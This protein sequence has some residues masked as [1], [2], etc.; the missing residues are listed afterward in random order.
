MGPKSEGPSN[1]ATGLSQTDAIANLLTGSVE[2]VAN[3]TKKPAV[4]KGV[5]DTVKADDEEVLQDEQITEEDSDEEETPSDESTDEEVTDESD[6][7]WE[8]ML[9]LEDGQ[10]DF[11]DKGNLRGINVKV[12][13]ESS[14]VKLAELVAGYQ[15]NKSNTQKSQALSDERRNFESQV[16]TLATEYQAKLDNAEVLTTFLSDKIVS[17]YN[18]INWER[19]RVENP[20][21]YAAAR[22]DYAYRAQ[23]IEQAK[24]ALAGER[25]QLTQAQQAQIMKSE[26]ASLQEQRAKMLANNPEWNSPERFE[27]DMG[28]IKTFLKGQY[29]FSDQDFASVRDARL[30]ELVKDAKKF[31]EGVKFAQK[32][33]AK[34]VPKF[35]KS[36]GK[37]TKTLS[38]LDKLTKAAK[39]ATGADKRNT[40]AEAVAELLMGGR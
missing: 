22:Q 30:I 38:K 25:Q 28:Q 3:E 37:S 34:P 29:G 4:D 27:Q 32:K 39:A 5:K 35:Q 31:R 2:A 20:A 12:N 11:D 24:A 14:T 23:E 33:I 9:G 10:I 40:Q 7:T 26:Q 8:K 36:S 21:E 19:L 16:K 13:G 15:N 6:T 18:N 1:Q 17:E